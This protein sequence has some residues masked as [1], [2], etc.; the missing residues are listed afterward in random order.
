MKCYGQQ[1]DNYYYTIAIQIEIRVKKKT[2][3]TWFLQQCN[4]IKY[5]FKMK[6]CRSVS[7]S[8]VILLFW[9]SNIVLIDEYWLKENWS[10]C[11][12]LE[13]NNKIAKIYIY[14]EKQ[15]QQ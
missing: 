11:Q 6:K 5:M 4:W 12:F 7:S 13:L 2:I 9:E 1:D 15:Q 10:L 3:R 14:V 8:S